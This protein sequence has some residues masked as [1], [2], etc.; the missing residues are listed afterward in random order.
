MKNLLQLNPRQYADLFTWS[1]PLGNHVI[2]HTDGA[3]SCMI[4]WDGIDAELLTAD[5]R[6][7]AWDS[8]YTALHSVPVG[9]VAEFH[10]WREK[11]EALADAYLAH[12]EKMSRPSEL[13]RVIRIEQSK[14]LR[15]VSRNN[16]VALVLTVPPKKAFFAGAKRALI[17]QSVVANDLLEKVKTITANLKGA[18]V[19][20]VADYAA[21]ICQS[22]DREKFKRGHTVGID[23]RF[24]LNEQLLRVAPDKDKNLL[25]CGDV[26][27]KVLL[28]YLYP[29]AQPAWFV[30]MASL[31]L[32]IHVVSILRPK[33]TR[34]ALKASEKKTDFAEGSLGR[35]GRSLQAR[36]VQ[37]LNDF[38][39]FVATNSL[40]IFDNA[41][42]IH[43]H[44]TREEVT[45]YAQSITD[46]CEP[47]GGQIRDSDYMQYP[48]FRSAMPGQGYR[49]PLLRPDHSWQVGNMLPVQV[50]GTG[51][52]EPESLRLGAS[53]Q[54]VGFG[55]SSQAVPHSFTVA[56]TGG[57]KGVDKVATIAE[58]YPF[59]I[60]WYIAEIGG[61]YKWVVEGY[62]GVYS[63]VD[64]SETVVNPLPPFSIADQTQTYPLN[65]VIAGGTVNSLAFLLTDGSTVLD[66]H[67]QRVAEDALQMLYAMPDSTREAPTL[68]DFLNEID[69]ADYPDEPQEAA[70]AKNMSSK[71]HSFLETTGG[72]VFTRQDNL[73]LSEGITGVDLKDVDRASPKML[74]F[75]LVF[76]ALRFSHL[77]FARRNPARVLL[78]EM[79]KFIAIAPEVMGKLISELAR[80]GRKDAAAIDLVTQGIAEIDCIEKE[81]LNSMPLRSLLYRADE[82]DTIA[83]RIAMPAGALAVWKAYDDPSNFNWRPGMRSVG[84][85]YYNLHLTFPKILLDL[86]ATGTQAGKIADL[87]LKDEI[88]SKISDPVERL[89]EF[90]RRR[91]S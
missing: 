37:D 68:P 2:A 89:R 29:D 76:L 67:Q 50:N 25:V 59:G 44:G 63:R 6:A 39:N 73:V 81:V 52:A 12:G 35:K 28:M 11:D 90:R 86:A 88:G 5:E 40:S 56:M 69:Q 70:A 26:Y 43:L 91:T 84:G 80:M 18:R 85:D 38:Q 49:V 9:W 87:D 4:E 72:R 45:Q 42:I 41:Y 64:P 51:E 65:A 15:R 20:S 58:T 74:K 77:A 83:E 62:G 14:H 61:S 34:E 79:H 22:I 21:R 24:M 60:D 48:Y 3:V 47:V 82:H 1:H 33:D 75:Y 27:T 66:I 57:G 10:W 31:P 23:P 32:D 19:S 46:W 36:V 13:A 53:G 71:L 8:L 78:D 17:N 55:I 54:L 16:S 30:G 7:L